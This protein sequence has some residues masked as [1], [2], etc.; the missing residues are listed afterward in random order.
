MSAVDRAGLGRAAQE[1]ASMASALSTSHSH[2][3]SSKPIN[4]TSYKCVVKGVWLWEAM[5][6]LV[7]SIMEIDSGMRIFFPVWYY[8]KNLT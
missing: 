4:S 7:V 8:R 5:F 2:P 3:H 6:G 1:L